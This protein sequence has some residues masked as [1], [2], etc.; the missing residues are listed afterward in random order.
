[1]KNLY[2]LASIIYVTTLLFSSCSGCSGRGGTATSDRSKKD[3]IIPITKDTI[4]PTVKPTVNVYIENS[5]SMDGYVN[6]IT[7]FEQT[8]YNYLSDILISHTADNLN[9]YYINSE[10]LK[11]N[12]PLE[13]FIQKLE[14]ANFKRYGGRRGKS[15][16]ANVLDSVLE[17]SGKNQ[18]SILVTDGI[19][20]PGRGQD[21]E[22]Y[23]IN[24]Q[25]GIKREFARFLERNPNA[26]VIVYQLSSN[27]KGSY[28]NKLDRITI[29][30]EQRPYY[31][32][33]I[34]D[35]KQLSNL[36]KQVPDSKFIN[37]GVQN[38]F[39]AI[40][41]NQPVKYAVIPGSGKFNPSRRDSH[42]IEN[43]E[44]DSRSGKIQFAVN[45]DF[46][47]LLLD[48]SYLLNVANYDNDSKY[49]LSIR[50]SAAKGSSYSH[51]LTFTSTDRVYAGNVSEKLKAILP[52]WIEKANDDEGITAVKGKTYG[53]K[54]QLSGVFDAFTFNNNYYTEIK[55]NI[56]K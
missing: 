33:V 17:K 13:D 49:A 11:P 19:F 29:I 32:W 34:G 51:I 44:K 28:Y 18:I 26:A 52:D 9:L 25:I 1:M 2:F 39:T 47:D 16:I 31:V 14:P 43:L 15:D 20:S 46:S 37:N 50:P 30:N 36:R 27:F 35:A 21:A 54:Y 55:I 24:Q 40:A 4:K 3:P 48:D 53:I 5:G 7:E 42:S 22:Q 38:V 12:L 8:V 45:A 10:I 56:N 41:G 6:G 23:L